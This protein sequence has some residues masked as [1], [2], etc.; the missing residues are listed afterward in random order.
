MLLI[1]AVLVAAPAVHPAPLPDTVAVSSSSA[2]E[3]SSWQLWRLRQ[4]HC[5]TASAVNANSCMYCYIGIAIVVHDIRWAIC[6]WG[7]SLVGKA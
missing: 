6:R 4:D 1:D 2:Q 5:R 3:D 7:S